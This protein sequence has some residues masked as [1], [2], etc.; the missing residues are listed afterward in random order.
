MLVRVLTSKLA[1]AAI[2]SAKSSGEFGLT[3]SSAPLF[4]RILTKAS[5][6]VRTNFPQAIASKTALST[7]PVRLKFTNKSQF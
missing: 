5:F 2:L 1:S 4:F 7:L 6:E 3:I